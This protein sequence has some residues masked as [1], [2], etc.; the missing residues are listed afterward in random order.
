MGKSIKNEKADK[1]MDAILTIENREEAYN[2][3][4]DLCTI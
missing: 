1:L 4:E 2:F 3:F